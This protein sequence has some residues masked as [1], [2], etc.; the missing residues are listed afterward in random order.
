MTDFLR[1]GNTG[2]L[3]RLAVIRAVDFGL[4]LAVA[5]ADASAGQ[6]ITN[7]LPVV[8]DALRGD[9]SL[10]VD[11][12]GERGG[13]DLVLFGNGEIVLSKDREERPD[14]RAPLPCRLQVAVIDDQ[15]LRVGRIG[16]PS[17]CGEPI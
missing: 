4:G 5:V 9:D 17:Y 16:N 10:L 7:V 14:F 12:E 2:N 11:Q 8:D 1:S 6:H 3:F 13:E 15:D